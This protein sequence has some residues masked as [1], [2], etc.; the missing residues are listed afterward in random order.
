[1]DAGEVDAYIRKP[2]VDALVRELRAREAFDQANAHVHVVADEVWPFEPG[3]R[4][5][6]PWVAWLDLEDRED[7][8]AVT[9]LERI[10][11]RRIHA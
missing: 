1:M 7:R 6:M 3:Q 10:G 9:L 2:D 5:V 11:G 8:A 4:F